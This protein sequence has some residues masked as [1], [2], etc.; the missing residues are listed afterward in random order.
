MAVTALISS[1]VTYHTAGSKVTDEESR[2]HYSV[3]E[4]AEHCSVELEK[5]INGENK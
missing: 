1:S 3:F 4:L 2:Y 5:S